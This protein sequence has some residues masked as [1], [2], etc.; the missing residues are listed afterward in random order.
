MSST[1]GPAIA[2]SRADRRAIRLLAATMDCSCVVVLHEMLISFLDK[3]PELGQLVEGAKAA[4][5]TGSK[6]RR[7]AED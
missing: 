1:A 2:C 5:S 6:S 4:D 3:H 7:I